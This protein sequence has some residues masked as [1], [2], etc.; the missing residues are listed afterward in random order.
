MRRQVRDQGYVRLQF[1]IFDASAPGD[2]AVTVP[3]GTWYSDA[4]VLD[5]GESP[6]RVSY[7][8]FE[9][10]RMRLDGTQRLLPES[11][12]ELAAQG[13]V[14]AA[15]CGADGVF[16]SPPVVSVAFGT[17]HSM[18]G[19]TLDF[20]DCVPAQ[21]T[22]RAYTAGALADTF[23]VTDALEPYYRGGVPPGGC[24]RAGNKLRQD[25]RAV[26]PCAAERIAV[27]RGLYV[28]KR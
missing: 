23:V 13:F 16:A 1:G 19:L 20:G 22:V 10:D 7:A 12:A 8:T 5:G 24:G 27:W 18:A 21:I 11:G 6:V 9:G 25:A 3:P 26:H 4:S 14:S 2:A 28:R 17:V 15:L